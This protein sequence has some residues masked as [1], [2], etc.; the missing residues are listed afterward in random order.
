MCMKSKRR[1]SLMLLS[2]ALTDSH[3]DTLSFPS[4]RWHSFSIRHLLCLC[5]YYYSY[6]RRRTWS[7]ATH[8]CLCHCRWFCLFLFLFLLHFHFPL[9]FPHNHHHRHP[10]N[11]TQTRTHR[12]GALVLAL[13]GACS[14]YTEIRK[15][16]LWPGLIVVVQPLP[17]LDPSALFLFQ[18]DGRRRSHFCSLH[19]QEHISLLT[20]ITFFF[21]EYRPRARYT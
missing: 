15:I 13:V 14:V 2:P 11:G 8:P 12:P 18:G 21:W 10:R 17:L 1:P 20:C 9:A 3:T 7:R 4:S 5:V 16:H 6:N 19:L